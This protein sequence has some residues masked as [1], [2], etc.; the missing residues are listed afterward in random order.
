[1]FDLLDLFEK[2]VFEKQ[3]WHPLSPNCV[4]AM[5]LSKDATHPI[6][7]N[8]VPKKGKNQWPRDDFVAKWGKIATRD[9]AK[10][11][12]SKA[13]YYILNAIL[14]LLCPLC[15]IFKQ[16]T[17]D[18]FTANHVSSYNNKG[19]WIDHFP[20]SFKLGSYG[21]NQC[22]A[23][24][25]AIRDNDTDGEGYIRT[26]MHKYPQLHVALTPAEKEAYASAYKAR[27]GQT[28]TKVP[29]T[30]GGVRW[31]TAQLGKECW[32]TGFAMLS[33]PVK[34]HPFNPSPNGLDIQEG[35]Y[36]QKKGHAPDRTVAVCAF[37]NV[38]QGATNIP[39]LRKAY[40]TL[41]ETMVADWLKTPEERETEEDE[42]FKTIESPIP[43][44]I[45]HV[46]SHSL[47]ADTKKGRECDL[48]TGADVV[49]RLKAVRMRCHTSGVLMSAESGWNKVHADRIDND[50]GHVDGNM[51][52]KCTLFVADYRLT[53]EQFLLGFLQQTRV[54]IPDGMR[55]QLE[56][57][58]M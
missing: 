40:I 14:Y 23:R 1:M 24:K 9:L 36:S 49:V 10:I 52:L 19:G 18:N 11:Q 48:R 8:G 17:T 47:E 50:I 39:N 27:T 25:L 55:A 41:Y 53:R 13:F 21:C 31:F 38:Q 42:V 51:E 29:R 26:I 35:G 3:K 22:W 30:D 54:A 20:H 16:A 43:M 58:I 2:T 6:G 57:E 5:V 46:A 12:A 44:V 45:C 15:K 34:G 28:L 56:R 32:A 37:V 33:K 4:R 7:N